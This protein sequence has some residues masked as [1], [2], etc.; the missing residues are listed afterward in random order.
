MTKLLTVLIA[1]AMCVGQSYAGSKAQRKY[2]QGKAM[3]ESM[4]AGI[5]NDAQSG[6]K[7]DEVSYQALDK[8][9]GET[10]NNSQKGQSTAKVIQ[11]ATMGVAVVSAAQCGP[12][13]PAACGM[14]A[15]MFLMS[16]QAGK[17]SNSFGY[18]ADHAA[19]NECTYSANTIGTC[20]SSNPYTAALSPGVINEGKLREDTAK[21]RESLSK[22]GFTVDVDS[23]KI[24]GPNGEMDVSNPAS[25]EAGLGSD[26]YAKMVS[27]LKDIEKDAKAKVDQIK[28]GVA[29]VENGGG[30]MGM[31]APADGYGQDGAEGGGAYAA[32]NTVERNPSA[33]GLTKNFNG[34]PIGVAAD[35]IF[36]MMSRRYQLKNTQKTFFNGNEVQ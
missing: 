34:E 7:I 26:A 27:Q 16:S 21:V 31:I 29:S 3:G 24:K 2:N 12:W 22:G 28:I 35:S 18:A 13:N 15:A 8:N 6:K 4:A 33:A 11:V 30:G 20:S 32:K 19:G 1:F 36:A 10:K 14:A 9:S 25:L 5:S 17:S 23:G